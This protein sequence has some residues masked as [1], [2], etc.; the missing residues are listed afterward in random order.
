M[1]DVLLATLHHLVVFSV[2]GILLSE[3]MLL[4]LP[5]SELALRLLARIDLGYGMGAGLVLLVGAARVFYGA[6]GSAFYL[7]NPMFWAKM[8]CFLV[9]G[10]ISIVPTVRFIR[11]SKALKAGGAL[12]EAGAWQSMQR[13]VRLQLALFI[14]LLLFAAMMARGFGF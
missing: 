8:G 6:K 10:L 12:P 5:P 14:L 1:A 3:H 13:W 2:F 7:E 4:S 11:W 9:V